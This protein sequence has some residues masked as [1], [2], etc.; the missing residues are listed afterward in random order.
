VKTETGEDSPLI[1]DG[2]IE[3]DVVGRDAVRCDEQ[4]FLWIDLVDLPDLA[5]GDMR[6]CRHAA[7]E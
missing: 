6:K 2:L 5:R 1:R 3:D 7:A 4:E